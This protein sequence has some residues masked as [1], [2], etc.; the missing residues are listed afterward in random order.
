MK[1][2]DFAIVSTCGLLLMVSMQL[3][4]KAQATGPQVYVGSNY[5]S[6]EHYNGHQYLVHASGAI[7]QLPD[8][9]PKPTIIVNPDHP[10]IGRDKYGNALKFPNE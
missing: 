10:F 4:D 2:I 7:C 3:Y 9:P 1:F 5:Y 8:P 6:I